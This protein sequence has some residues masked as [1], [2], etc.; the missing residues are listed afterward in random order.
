MAR[1]IPELAVTQAK[2]FIFLSQGARKNLKSKLIGIPHQLLCW[3]NGSR[4]EKQ[5][6]PGAALQNK[7]N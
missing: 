7:L 5:L 4:L 2:R 6:D 1:G 3:N